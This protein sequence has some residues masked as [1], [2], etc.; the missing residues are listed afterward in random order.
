MLPWRSECLSCIAA[1]Q[2]APPRSDR[3]KRCYALPFHYL[4]VLLGSKHAKHVSEMLAQVPVQCPAPMLRDEYHVIFA[5]PRHVAQTCPS[6][7]F[8]SCVWRLTIGT[9]FDGQP[10]I[11]Q[12][13]TASPTEPG[14]PPLVARAQTAS[15]RYHIFRLFIDLGSVLRSPILASNK[16]SSIGLSGASTI[17]FRQT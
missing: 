5:V 9:F 7:F 11:R 13:F 12:T 8:L 15:H 1:E 17:A 14:G 6:D 10:G 4:A 3:G 16:Q 2:R